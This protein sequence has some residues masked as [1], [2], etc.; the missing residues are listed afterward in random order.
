ME[1]WLERAASPDYWRALCPE[2][3][4]GGAQVAPA[5]EVNDALRTRL[6]G[7]MLDDGYFVLPSVLDPTPMAAMAAAVERL[8]EANVP[9]SFLFVYD[10]PWQTSA[11]AGSI[12]STLLGAD[13][14]V[15]PGLW[16]W[17]VAGGERGWEPHREHGFDRILANGMPASL[18]LWIPITDA[19]PANGCIYCLPAHADP[20]YAARD[21]DVEVT[22]PQSVRALP[23]PAGSILGWN[24][25]LIH[26]GGCADLEVPAPRVAINLEYQRGDLAPFER[27][28]L[29]P[30]SLPRFEHRLGLLGRQFEHYSGHFDP[31]PELLAMA[32]AL[33]QRFPVN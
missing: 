12:L 2:L 23:A 10:Q 9:T 3:T 4:I 19:T 30:W 27:P 33:R 5:L 8:S 6:L 32:A 26:W 31:P 15:V 25:A 29:D 11:W 18:S 28:L 24:H 22:D 1:E 14:R 7:A 16:A 21:D 20:L 17:R 13:F